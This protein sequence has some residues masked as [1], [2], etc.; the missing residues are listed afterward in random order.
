MPQILLVSND[1]ALMST[2]ALVL[3]T[4]GADVTEVFPKDYGGVI[5][6]KHF[7][8]VFLCHSLDND[9]R[10]AIARKSREQ[11]QQVC[12][13]QV[14]AMTEPGLIVPQYADAAVSCNPSLLLA[15]T[16]RL[17]AQFHEPSEVL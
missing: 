5:E 2:R 13:I 11:W 6:Q 7:H 3:S 17:L 14:R 12:V 16:K 10:Q 1:K 4:T 15:M 9:E 8:L